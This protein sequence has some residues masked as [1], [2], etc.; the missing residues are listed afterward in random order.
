MDRQGPHPAFTALKQPDCEKP[1]I[2]IL[3]VWLTVP[4]FLP[5]LQRYEQVVASRN[6]LAASLSKA[7]RYVTHLEGELAGRSADVSAAADSLAEVSG[8]LQLLL[9]QAGLAAGETGSSGGAQAFALTQQL[10]PFQQVMRL[11]IPVSPPFE[12]W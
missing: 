9:R 12:S 6:R 5:T 7:N 1:G 8:Q 4:S 2:A 11:H 10:A 3:L